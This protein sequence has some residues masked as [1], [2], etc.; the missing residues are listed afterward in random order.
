M[1]LDYWNETAMVM[2]T[3]LSVEIPSFE[4]NISHSQKSPYTIG[5]FSDPNLDEINEEEKYPTPFSKVS[6]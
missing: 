1:L 3:L 6:C 4:I 2:Q 5:F